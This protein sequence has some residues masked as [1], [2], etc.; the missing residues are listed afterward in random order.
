LLLLHVV[1][2]YL[3]ALSNRLCTVMTG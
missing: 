3:E 2:Y 1:N